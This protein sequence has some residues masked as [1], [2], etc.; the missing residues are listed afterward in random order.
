MCPS[1]SFQNS[2][3]TLQPV[4]IIGVVISEGEM[5]T[6]NLK[7][8]CIP[9]RNVSHFN[10]IPHMKLNMY[11]KEQECCYVYYSFIHGQPS[12]PSGYTL[13]ILDGT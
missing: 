3:C 6:A 7:V 9:I 1:S 10:V 8:Y 2:K 13:Y 12:R 11:S 4:P 5:Y